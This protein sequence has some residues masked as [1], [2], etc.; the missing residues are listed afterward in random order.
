MVVKLLFS[1]LSRFLEKR[2]L[3]KKCECDFCRALKLRRDGF[4]A[5]L[6]SGFFVGRAS[7][8]FYEIRQVK[9]IAGQDNSTALIAEALLD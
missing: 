1:T 5:T 6:S 2:F 7:L 8:G 9:T 4:N 3:E